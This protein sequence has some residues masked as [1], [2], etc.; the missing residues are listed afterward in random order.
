MMM[1]QSEPS[2]IMC[3]IAV[4]VMFCLGPGDTSTFGWLF[5]TIGI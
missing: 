2:P 4:F 5:D 1:G 3:G